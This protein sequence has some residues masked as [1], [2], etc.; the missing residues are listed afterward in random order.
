V[1]KKGAGAAADSKKKKPKTA[2]SKKKRKATDSSSFEDDV[3]FGDSSDHSSDSGDVADR[4]PLES[5][6]DRNEGEDDADDDSVESGDS[7]GGEQAVLLNDVQQRRPGQRVG[8]LRE[9][10]ALG[11]A[12]SLSSDHEDDG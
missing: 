11:V 9:R 8:D 3:D 12:L 5:L 1:Q 4:P 2:T 10:A 7:D 6:F